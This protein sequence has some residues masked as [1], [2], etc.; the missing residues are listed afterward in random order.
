MVL[1]CTVLATISL[2][3]HLGHR[4]AIRNC[5]RRCMEH[6]SMY[7]K[8]PVQSSVYQTSIAYTMSTHTTRYEPAVEMC[9]IQRGARASDRVDWG[10]KPRDRRRVGKM[11]PWYVF[12]AS[13]VYLTMYLISKLL[14]K[15][16]GIPEATFKELHSAVLQSPRL[17]PEYGGGYIG[18]L[19]VSHHFHVSSTE[20]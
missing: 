16:A 1:Q 6:V 14:V 3:F 15:C 5:D 13:E 8:H 9:L 4:F 2:S 7:C 17:T 18:F 20:A 11:G 12:R 10:F 19:E